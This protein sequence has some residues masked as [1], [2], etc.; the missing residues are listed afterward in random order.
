MDDRRVRSQREERVHRS[1]DATTDDDDLA[2]S[3]VLSVADAR[4]RVEIEI[5]T[6]G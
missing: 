5:V 4:F 3:H 6:N 2:G 1:E